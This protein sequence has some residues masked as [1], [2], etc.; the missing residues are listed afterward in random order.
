MDRLAPAGC[1]APQTG[2][3]HAVS[4]RIG[5]SDRA[6]DGR[7]DQV[8]AGSIGMIT[9]WGEQSRVVAAAIGLER[10]VEIGV[11]APASVATRATKALNCLVRASLAAT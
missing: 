7:G 6:G 4:R 5:K 2:H 11:R 8:L 1:A 9:V 3:R 10:G